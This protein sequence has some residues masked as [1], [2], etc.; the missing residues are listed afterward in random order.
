MINSKKE[1]KEYMRKD[2]IACEGSE[3][4][5]IKKRIA[6]LFRPMIWKYEVKLRKTEYWLNV[7]SSTPIGRIIFHIK[8]IS[9]VNYG[10]KLGY[11]IPL[12]VIGPGLCLAHAGTIVINKNVKIGSNARIHID[13]N[14]GNSSEFGDKHVDTNVP[15]IGDNVYIGPGAKIYGKITIGNNVRIGA[16]AVVN[17]DVSDDVTVAGIPAKVISQKGSHHGLQAY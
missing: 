14:I 17:K 12:N 13:V 2:A 16:N 3:N 11:S 8:N 1:L 7:H 10:L 4:I 6:G 15:V 9:L 5:P